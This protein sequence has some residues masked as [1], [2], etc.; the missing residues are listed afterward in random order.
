MS[1]YRIYTVED[2]IERNIIEPPMDGNHGEAHPKT[3]DFVETGIP[4]IM[5]NN[6]LNGE[7]NYTSCAYISDNTASVLR[8][9]FSKNGDV[10][11]THKGTVGRTAIVGD[12]FNE[13]ILTPQVTYY[14]VKGEM[15]NYFL[16]YYFDSSFFQSILSA[17]A[18]TGSTRPYIGI[19]AQRKLPILYPPV[20]TQN[21]IV[22]ALR[23]LDLK[24]KAN[25][26]LILAIS[27]IISLIYQNWFNDFCFTNAT[28]ELVFN[29]KFE[30]KIPR[31]WDVM[32]FQEFL[33]PH[34]EKIG[35]TTAPIYST[36]NNGVALRDEKFNKNLAKSQGNNKKVV[37]DD[38]IFGL[39]REILNF[40]VFSNEIGSV[41]PAYQIFK[42]NQS[43]IL[44]F[45][46]ELEMRINM[47]YYMDILQL[48]SRE[49]QGIRKDYLMN[50]YFLVPKM[51]IQQEFFK[52]YE[53]FQK[54]IAKLKE[55]NAVLA[56]IRDTLLPK[57]MSGELPLKEGEE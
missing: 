8:K 47:P 29:D 14:R 52:H 26:K 27:D 41:S 4:F 12:E 20:E 30:R 44:P 11:L 42:I 33:T 13:I 16:K 19:T 22:N 3:S 17:A 15:N 54:K 56:E 31:G 36:T 53:T 37:K 6:L 50:K 40:G 34:T 5:A 49:G 10:L 35:E 55:E 45:M 23:P 28:E 48:G 1:I 32:Q 24:I 46:L 43:V 2:L 38:L 18:G 57:L 9:G 7:V 39:S 21:K 51:E 25:N